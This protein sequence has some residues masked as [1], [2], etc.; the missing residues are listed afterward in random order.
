MKGGR[1]DCSIAVVMG[2]LFLAARKRTLV[3]EC[4]GVPA[5]EQ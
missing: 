3:G 5:A 2:R 1:A 4:S